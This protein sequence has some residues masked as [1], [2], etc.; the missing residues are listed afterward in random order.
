[1]KSTYANALVLAL[2]AA[3]SSYATAGEQGFRGNPASP[4]T[5]VTASKSDAQIQAELTEALRTG[6]MPATGNANS[7]KKLYEVFPGRYPARAVA[8]GSGQQL[9]QASADADRW[10]FNRGHGN[11]AQ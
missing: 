7:G 3:A 9:A 2:A 10:V 6:D 4:I 11:G 5:T 8:Q 1:M